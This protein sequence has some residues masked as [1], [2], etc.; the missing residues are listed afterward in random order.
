MAQYLPWYQNAIIYC[1]DLEKF[2]DGNGDGI[3]DF[4]GLAQKLDY[5]RGLGVD[6][7]WLLPFFRS[8]QRDNGYDVSDYY[9]IDPRFGT[10]DDFIHFVHE[11]HERGIRLIVELVMDHTSD[12]HP[13]FRAARYDPRSRYRDYYLWSD[14]PILA[15]TDEPSF[16][17]EVDTLWDWDDVSHSYYFHRFYPFQ[18]NLNLAN[19]DVVE[20]LKRIMDYWLSFGADGFRIDALPLMFQ[21]PGQEKGRPEEVLREMREVLRRRKGDEVLLAEVDLPPE[22]M[23]DY[24]GDGEHVDMMQNFMLRAFIL[25]SLV[26]GSSAVLMRGLDALPSAANRF[27]WLSFLTSHDELNLS[28]LHPDEMKR[29]I[30]TLSPDPKTH[31]Y[32]RGVRRRILPLV[33]DERRY[34][35]LYSLLFSLPGAPLILYGDELGLGDDLTQEGREAVRV[36]MQWDD[37]RNG[38]FSTARSNSLVHPP[39]TD[40]P[41]GFKRRNVEAQSADGESLLSWFK[42]LILLRRQCTE[43]GYG[44]WRHLDTDNDAVFAL[45]WDWEG[46]WLIAAHNLT[47]RPQKIQIQLDEYSGLEY[48]LVFGEAGAP[49]DGIVE[50]GPYGFA[51]WRIPYTRR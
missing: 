48:E 39:I 27:Q 22:Q 17:G 30:D 32:G 23:P 45:K 26:D 2:A 38:G 1:I 46:R 40:G 7:L 29:I 51:W 21:P 42:K 35:M 43:V 5:L 36:L 34:R 20:E 15:P 49:K 37:S 13:W 16:P 50:L 41:F 24:I 47:D 44:S 11:A 14:S 8:P 19:R 33:G 31:S 28:R 6:C 3:G 18:P 4:V 9:S 10:F 25:L 12:E